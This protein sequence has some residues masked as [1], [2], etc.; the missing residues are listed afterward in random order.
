MIDW[1]LSKICGD[2]LPSDDVIAWLFKTY[3]WVI[4]FEGGTAEYRERRGLILPTQ[5]NFPIQELHGE[6]LA[7]HV[8][9][10]VIRH[11][12][13]EAMR[14]ALVAQDIDP[15]KNMMGVLRGGI[16]GAAGTYLL[17]EDGTARITY[18]PDGL[19]D[20]PTFI[21]T[22]AHEL[23][24]YY[25][26]TGPGEVPGGDSAEEHATDATVIFLGMGILKT[27]SVYHI[28]RTVAGTGHGHL[29]YLGEVPSAY[30]LA[31]YSELHG[32]KPSA[33]TGHLKSN[34]SSYFH[35]ALRD[36]KKRWQFQMQGLRQL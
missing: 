16:D 36:I 34:P 33:L 19:A 2:T 9:Q 32:L 18:D 15:R 24:H 20:M 22:M 26:R 25:I 10:M 31:M 23:A 1:L 28:S 12:R 14:Y 13:L 27:N 17:S 30:A 4:R 11:M 8:F 35:G 5:A 21:A 3:A 7:E 29:G 6:M